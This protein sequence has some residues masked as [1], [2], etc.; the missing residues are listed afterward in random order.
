MLVEVFIMVNLAQLMYTLMLYFS[1]QALI[2]KDSVNTASLCL[3]RSLV[4][5]TISG[6]KYAFFSEE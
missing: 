5:L 2:G 6:F 1:K 3:Y 4:L